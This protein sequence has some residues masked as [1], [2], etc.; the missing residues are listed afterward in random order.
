V[1]PDVVPVAKQQLGDMILR[2]EVTNYNAASQQLQVEIQ[3]ALLG[4]KSSQQALDD[5]AKAFSSS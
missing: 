2:P 5:A 4:K 1:L 3:K